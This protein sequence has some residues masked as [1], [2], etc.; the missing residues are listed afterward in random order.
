MR[1]S[2]PSGT[3]LRRKVRSQYGFDN[4]VGQTV[5]MRR[6]SDSIPWVT[7]GMQC[8]CVASGTG[9]EL[10]ANAIHYKLTSRL[11]P[12]HQAQLCRPA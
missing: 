6:S 3:V 7:G 4:M 12:L 1:R 2:A 10:I 9:K 8:W 11:R 5:V